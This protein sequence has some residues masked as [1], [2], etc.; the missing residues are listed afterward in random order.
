MKSFCIKVNNKNIQNYLLNNFLDLNLDSLF[1]S[2][3]KFSKY[4]NI[5]VHYKG[6]DLEYFYKQFSNIMTDCILFYYEDILLKKLIDFDYF[7]FSEFE[8]RQILNIASSY[9]DL[10]NEYS[11]RYTLILDAVYDYI[12]SEKSMILGGFVFFRLYNYIKLLDTLIDNSVNQFLIQK[13]YLEF[14]NLL[15]VFVSS[16]PCQTEAVHLIYNDYHS[17]I[18]DE[19]YNIIP[20]NND[21]FK[22]KYISDI[23]FSEN[24]YILNTLLTIL[25]K[26][27]TIHF[28]SS[29]KEDEFIN[30]LK[31]IFEKRIKICTDCSICNL[32]KLSK[33]TKNTY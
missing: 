24:D 10:D 12:K 22:A 31:Q 18:L 27:I 14:I 20:I 25:P 21:F 1:V 23:S 30:T 26:K 2:Q 32:Y 3:N 17:I 19:T 4:E 15:K 9:L 13:E 28:I 5:V 7:Y 29:T 16:S 6:E 33:D 8:K 11:K